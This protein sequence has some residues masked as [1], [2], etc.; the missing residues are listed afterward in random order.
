MKHRPPFDSMGPPVS[1]AS[2]SW[3]DQADWLLSIRPSVSSR[4]RLIS[5]YTYLGYAALYL[6]AARRVAGLRVLDVGCGAGFG[7]YIL[8]QNAQRVLALDR[9]RIDVV[10]AHH[11]YLLPRLSFLTADALHVP[12]P[13]QSIDLVVSMETYEHIPP[14]YSSHFLQE[15]H[16]VLAP[17]GRLIISTPNRDVYRAISRTAGHINELSIEEFFGML[18]RF[19]PVVLPYYQRKNELT[20]QKIYHRLAAHRNWR[21]WL[22]RGMKNQI[23]RLV[24][25][26]RGQRPAKM[27]QHL[28][29]Q[30]AAEL[31][32][33]QDAV[34]QLAVCEKI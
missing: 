28:A 14:E 3:T 11:R 29:V 15:L 30:P 8:A 17:G 34:I 20:E 25:H 23:L 9:Q 7:A 6:F 12:L 22:P 27:L 31:D 26:P 16:R 18:T 10:K 1:S 4:H 32:E 5:D 13:D 24:G 19:F 2:W 33:L 21:R